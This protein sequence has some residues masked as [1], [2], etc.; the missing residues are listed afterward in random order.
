MAFPQRCGSV[1]SCRL[2][3]INDNDLSTVLCEGYSCGSPDPTFRCS[4]S[5]DC[6]FALKKHVEYL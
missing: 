6:D 1:T 2:V 5:D 3:Q 4:A